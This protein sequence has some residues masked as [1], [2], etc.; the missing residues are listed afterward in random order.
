MELFTTIGKVD[1][2]EIG[3]ESSGRSKGIG[4]VQFDAL[5]TSDSA[6]QKFQG[7]MYGGR[8]SPPSQ[9]FSMLTVDHLD[10]RLSN[11]SLLG[12][13]WLKVNSTLASLSNLT[14]FYLIEEKNLIS[15][16]LIGF[17]QFLLSFLSCFDGRVSVI[18]GISLFWRAS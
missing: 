8:Y 7:Y 18:I 14:F 15:I 5:E 16:V 9:K 13:A 11:T 3:Y 6:I 1:R 12:I 17:L 4:V 10:C 2:A